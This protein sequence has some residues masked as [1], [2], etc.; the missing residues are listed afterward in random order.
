MEGSQ[1]ESKATGY[2]PLRECSIV[3]SDGQEALVTFFTCPIKQDWQQRILALWRIEWDTGDFNWRLALSGEYAKT[4]KIRTVVAQVAGKDAAT[5]TIT[6]S[7]RRPEVAAMTNV[8]THPD[9]RRRGTAAKLTGILVDL[10]FK[11]GCQAVYLG[12]SRRPDPVYLRAG[13]EW[14]NGGVMRRIAE[15]VENFEKKYFAPGQ[16]TQTRPAQWGDLAATAC[17]FTRPFELVSADYSRGLFSGRYVHQARCTSNFAY[18]YDDVMARGGICD[19]LVGEEPHRVLGFA[20]LTPGLREIQ[21]SA[22]VLDFLVHETYLGD[23]ERLVAD[24]LQAGESKDINRVTAYVVE[25]DQV[26]ASVLKD[27][28]FSQIARV[29]DQLRVNSQE[30]AVLVLHK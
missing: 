9:F 21:R 17:L 1:A 22:A 5:A 30:V 12:T 10:A 27:L 7:V 23:S 11:D 20:S 4:L 13:F 24:V 2:E 28:G 14:Y 19:V 15:N 25:L 3:L 8:V 26:K 6:Y 16:S 29:P 18:V